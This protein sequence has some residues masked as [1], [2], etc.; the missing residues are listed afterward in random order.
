MQEG[1]G[2]WC[3]SCLPHFLLLPM[4]SPAAT[5]N[6]TRL[7]GPHELL[8]VVKV[9]GCPVQVC[10]SMLQGFTRH[11]NL[12][13][14]LRTTPW[15]RPTRRLFPEGLSV[16]QLLVSV[17]VQT[18]NPLLCVV[19]ASSSPGVPPHFPGSPRNRV[20]LSACPCPQGGS[21]S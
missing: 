14:F 12:C 7:R 17:P 21:R 11:Q 9:Y 13:L 16:P 18:R 2:S 8:P 20:P 5:M 6:H 19:K 10:H 1:P 3:M 15:L 4:A